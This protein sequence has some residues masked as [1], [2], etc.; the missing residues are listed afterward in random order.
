MDRKTDQEI[1]EK[2]EE[3]DEKTICYLRKEY[4]PMVK[5]MV[6]NYKYSDGKR[7]ISAELGNTKN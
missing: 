1:L 5:Y 7:T 4:L 6:Q 3:R 2:I